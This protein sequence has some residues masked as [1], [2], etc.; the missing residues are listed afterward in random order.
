MSGA[1]TPA[2]WF[3]EADNGLAASYHLRRAV[4]TSAEHEANARLI[5]AAPEMLAALV[6]AR[7]VLAVAIQANWED[8]TDEDVAE[9]ITVK[10]MDAAITKAG[11][12]L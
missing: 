8:S 11:G 5:A 2:P 7:K 12:A 1:H 3:I 10:Q 9:H 6:Q 4:I